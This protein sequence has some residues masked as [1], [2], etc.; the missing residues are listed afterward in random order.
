MAHQLT[1]AEEHN[2]LRGSYYMGKHWCVKMYGDELPPFREDTHRLR[3]VGR[4][5]QERGGEWVAVDTV[6]DTKT[7]ELSLQEVLILRM[8]WGVSVALIYQGVELSEDT[9]I[10]DIPDQSLSEWVRYDH[11]VW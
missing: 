10:S 5:Y 11:N 9:K 1:L 3:A 4:G 6:F 2:R 8:K 7:F